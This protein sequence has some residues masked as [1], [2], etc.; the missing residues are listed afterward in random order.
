MFAS[1]SDDCAR[2][3]PKARRCTGPRTLHCLQ[4][5]LSYTDRSES[6]GVPRASEEYSELNFQENAGRNFRQGLGDFVGEFQD[7][8]Q[9]VR[10]QDDDADLSTHGIMLV[11]QLL[12]SHPIS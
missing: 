11:F 3:M 5:S 8:P 1:Q 12:M 7:R 9:M 6:Y 10:R 4:E 2:R